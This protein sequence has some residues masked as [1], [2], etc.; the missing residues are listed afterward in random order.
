MTRIISICNLKG[1]VGK[2]TVATNL[3]YGLALQ[4]SKV[5]VIDADLQASSTEFFLGEE[6]EETPGLFEIMV[7][8]NKS[9]TNEE[10]YDIKDAIYH[11]SEDENIDILP[12]ST[13]MARLE[14]FLISRSGKTWGILKKATRN[15]VNDYDYV[16]IDCPPVINIMVGNA[17]YMSDEVIIPTSLNVK[18]SRRMYATIEELKALEED[19]ENAV[20]IRV[21][22]NIVSNTKHDKLKMQETKEKLDEIQIP[23]LQTTIRNRVNPIDQSSEQRKP[24]FVTNTNIGNEFISLI[25]EIGGANNEWI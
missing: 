13:N 7:Q 9:Y 24:V 17:Y 14:R 22:F 5:L 18:A 25:D 23:Y 2:T 16:I 10:H 3:A 21:L 19:Y 8:D 15:I 12:S 4:G 1:G 11:Y 20:D 6:F